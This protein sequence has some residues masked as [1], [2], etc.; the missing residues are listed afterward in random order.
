[1]QLALGQGPGHVWKGTPMFRPRK[2]QSLEQ[3]AAVATD[4]DE[5]QIGVTLE[6]SGDRADRLLR[7]GE[8]RAGVRYAAVSGGRETS[9]Y[10]EWYATV[11]V[12][13]SPP[14][15]GRDRASAVVRGFLTADQNVDRVKTLLGPV[16][17]RLTAPGGRSVPLD[18][19]HS[20][21]EAAGLTPFPPPRAESSSPGAERSKVLR[22]LSG[23]SAGRARR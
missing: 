17:V 13:P 4:A 9:V 6:A 15:S 22:L 7:V 3:F 14:A 12:S 20:D 18:Q 10:T 5:V 8:H 23:R 1:M 19:L 11:L 16:P 21:A 2:P